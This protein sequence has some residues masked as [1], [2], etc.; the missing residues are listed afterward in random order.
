MVIK[1][2]HTL[3]DD[4]MKIRQEVFVEEQKFKDE[5]D[6]IDKYCITLVGY[7]EGKPVACSRAFFDEE[8]KKY[9]VGRFAVLKDYR[10]KGLGL[11]ML[12]ATCEVIKRQGGTQVWLHSQMQAVGFYEKLGFVQTGEIGYEEYCPHIWMVKKV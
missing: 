6:E 10:G 12:Q 11:E 2:F 8:E 5:F 7:D 4:A 1:E 9:K 3:C